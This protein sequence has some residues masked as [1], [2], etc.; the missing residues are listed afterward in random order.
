MADSKQLIWTRHK[1]KFFGEKMNRIAR[2]RIV[3]AALAALAALTAPAFAA[4]SSSSGRSGGSVRSVSRPAAGAEV[5][6]ESAQF[7]A[8]LGDALAGGS[9]QDALALFDGF[10]TED[11]GLLSLKA[12]LLLSSGDVKGADSVASAL[13][14][15]NPNDIDVLLANVMVAK[16][17]GDA[18]KKNQYLRKI[19]SLDPEN[20]DANIELGDE[21]ALRKNYGAALKFYKKAWMR[22]PNNM[23]ALFGCGKMNYYLS[24]DKDAMQSF[25]RMLK[26]EP[27]NAQ[28]LAYLGKI[29]GENRRYRAAAEYARR[30]TKSDPSNADNFLDLGTFSRFLGK[31]DDAEAAWIRATELD[32]DYFLAYAY[33]AGLYDERENDAKAYEN[34][35]KVIQ[36]NP[37]YYYAYESVGLYSWHV[38]NVEQCKAAFMEAAKRNPDNVSYPLMVTACLMKQNK[39][40]EA[41]EY[42]DK[43]MRKLDRKSLDYKTLRMFHDQMGDDEVARLVQQEDNRTRRGK[44]LYYLALYFDLKGNSSLAQ[45]YYVEI[46]SIQSPMFFEYKLAKWAKNP[47]SGDMAARDVRSVTH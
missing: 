17:K 20:V 28:A 39:L 3:P 40:Q 18:V 6:A 45:K 16:S 34:Y 27:E 47:G 9:V 43:A 11:A 1:D 31:Y 5:S 14:K 37:Q 2:K 23:E 29:E 33:L 44:F 36:K 35:V 12:S 32:P 46:C 26:V 15:K 30:A 7:A 19:I 42:S 25:Q 10:Q 8:R 21:Q 24:H 4:S 13:L 41:R 38:G 22:E